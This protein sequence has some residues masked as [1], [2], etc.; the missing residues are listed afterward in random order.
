M[1]RKQLFF[2][3]DQSYGCQLRAGVVMFIPTTRGRFDPSQGP[4]RVGK[5]HCTSCTE[6]IYL[7]AT[8]VTTLVVDPQ[9]K[10]QSLNSSQTAEIR[11]SE[12]LSVSLDAK[13]SS[14]HSIVIDVKI[15]D[16]ETHKC[17]FLI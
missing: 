7:G 9:K 2:F 14:G 8:P 11:F 16:E 17:W 1:Y 5:P 12:K 6:C 4:R 3:G 10:Q 15:E 13:K